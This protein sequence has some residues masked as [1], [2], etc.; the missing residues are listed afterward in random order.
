MF[1]R[2]RTR[3]SRVL[4]VRPA[5]L[6]QPQP[7]YVQGVLRLAPPTRPLVIDPE[8]RL[9]RTSMRLALDGLVVAAGA[10]QAYS[11]GALVFST[12]RAA[13]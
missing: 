9:R 10:G 2:I 1:H 6:T 12:T 7:P 11:A 3:L 4:R 8:R 5:V 13:V